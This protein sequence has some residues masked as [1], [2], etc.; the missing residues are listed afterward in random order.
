MGEEGMF[1][2]SKL[3]GAMDELMKSEEGKALAEKIRTKLKELNDQYKDLTG[4][5]K[6]NFKEQ[7]GEKFKDL[8]GDLSETLKNT[9]DDGTFQIRDDPGVQALAGFYNYLPFLLAVSFICLIFGSFV[10]EFLA[11]LFRNLLI[12]LTILVLL[13]FFGRKLYRSIKEK[14]QKKERKP[15]KTP[16]AGSPPGSPQSRKQK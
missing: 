12:L 6:K 9:P 2:S 11:I 15:K 10:I 7:F 1:K 16:K 3:K 13:G 5:D 8:V 14:E 4:D